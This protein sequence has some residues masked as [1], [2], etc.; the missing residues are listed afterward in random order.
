MPCLS[1]SPE[2]R[3]NNLSV[4]RSGIVKPEKR[5]SLRFS[6]SHHIMISNLSILKTDRI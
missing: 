4:G 3:V 1:V 2:R 6:R 5:P